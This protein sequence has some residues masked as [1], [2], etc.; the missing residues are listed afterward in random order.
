MPG[1]PERE[2]RKARANGIA[3]DAQTLAQLDSAAAQVSVSLPPLSSLGG[4]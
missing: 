2:S 4:A 1:D 3:I